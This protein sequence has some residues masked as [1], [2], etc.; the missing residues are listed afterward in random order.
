MINF[1]S[2]WFYLKKILSMETYIKSSKNNN[3]IASCITKIKGQ[4][5][6]TV[7]VHVKNNQI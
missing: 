2:G 1:L 7:T 3:K 6:S 5:T 4:V